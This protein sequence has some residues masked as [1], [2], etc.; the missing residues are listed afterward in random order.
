MPL[1][2]N[3]ARSKSK[4]FF[5]TQAHHSTWSYFDLLLAATTQ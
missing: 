3:K 1:K 4:E 2:T 5:F